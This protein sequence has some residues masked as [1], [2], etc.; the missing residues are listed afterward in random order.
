MSVDETQNRMNPPG[1]TV[2]LFGYTSKRWLGGGHVVKFKIKI[3]KLF[4]TFP[5]KK[6][7]IKNETVKR[8]DIVK[9]K[10]IVEQKIHF[11]PKSCH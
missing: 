5:L 7:K 11:C 8:Q 10:F 1:C 4:V 2:Q 9:T 6:I 3:I